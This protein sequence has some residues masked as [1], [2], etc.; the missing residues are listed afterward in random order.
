MI[1]DISI[2][3]NVLSKRYFW[4][5]S[6]CIVQ[7]DELDKTKYLFIIDAIYAHAFLT[8]VNAASSDT[9]SYRNEYQNEPRIILCDPDKDVEL[10]GG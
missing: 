9:S 3:S 5:G 1:F 4:I 7:G 10:T 2:A 6:L 8:I